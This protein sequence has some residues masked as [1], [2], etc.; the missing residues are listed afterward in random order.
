MATRVLAGG[1]L[2]AKLDLARDPDVPT[3]VIDGE[4]HRFLPTTPS[5]RHLVAL[6]DAV[7]DRDL[8]GEEI[9]ID[10]LRLENVGPLE[11]PICAVPLG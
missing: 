3:V 10:T 9:D 4:D 5:G 7:G 8:P 1:V 6:P 2:D 11:A